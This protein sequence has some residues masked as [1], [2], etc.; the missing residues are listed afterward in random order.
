MSSKIETADLYYGLLEN[1]INVSAARQQTQI[2]VPNVLT[3]PDM[4]NGD[5]E[6]LCYKQNPHRKN[7][8]SCKRERF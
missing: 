3:G 6:G 7:S 5:L 8:K 1:W 2:S 4:R